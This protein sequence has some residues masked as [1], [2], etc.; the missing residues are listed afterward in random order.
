MAQEPHAGGQENPAGGSVPLNMFED[1][2][3]ASRFGLVNIST[4]SIISAG[5]RN[6]GALEG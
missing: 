4:E 1:S 6:G 2:Q 5:A 3:F